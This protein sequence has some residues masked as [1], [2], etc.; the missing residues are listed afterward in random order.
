MIASDPWIMRQCWA[1]NRPPPGF[2]GL[3][4]HYCGR[5]IMGQVGLGLGCF[6]PVHRV[7]QRDPLVEGGER[8]ELDAAPQGGL[9]DE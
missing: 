2:R 9:P 6:H 4:P 3:A 7:A 5:R 8:P 1:G